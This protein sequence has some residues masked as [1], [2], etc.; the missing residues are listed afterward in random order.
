MEQLVQYRCDTAL[1]IDF[2]THVA[3]QRKTRSE[4]LRGLMQGWVEGQ[5]KPHSIPWVISSGP[6]PFD[7]EP[8]EGAAMGLSDIGASLIGLVGVNLPE[9]STAQW[10]ED[11]FKALCAGSGTAVSRKF[12]TNESS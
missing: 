11:K 4:V 9:D 1:M 6:K 10:S 7:S 8:D 3:N 2:D 12:K 5:D